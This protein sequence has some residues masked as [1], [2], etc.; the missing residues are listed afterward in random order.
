MLIDLSLRTNLHKLR[1][2]RLPP[3]NAAANQEPLSRPI[4]PP[5][6][7]SCPIRAASQG[8]S[9]LW[10]VGPHYPKF[11]VYPQGCAVL[12]V[13]GV[14]WGLSARKPHF[15][16]GVLTFSPAPSI[17][18]SPPLSLFPSLPLFLSLS[19]C[20]LSACI[21][22]ANFGIY[23]LCTCLHVPVCMFVCG[24]LS[25]RIPLQYVSAPP[26][27]PPWDAIVGACAHVL[28]LWVRKLLFEINIATYTYIDLPPP[29]FSASQL[30]VS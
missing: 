6:S 29:T 21:P 15:S 30:S 14:V 27:D 24:L 22:L 4:L 2:H 23:P 9:E 16:S 12:G 17:F 13:C 10:H 28:P 1:S 19:L 11:P 25:F 3:E 20:G 18:F 26:S 7:S 5:A 8:A